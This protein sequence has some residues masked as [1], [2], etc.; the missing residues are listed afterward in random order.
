MGFAP[1]AML[2]ALVLTFVNFLKYLVNKQWNGAVTQ[3]IS[4]VSGV[5][6][7]VLVASTDWAEGINV[8]DK[9]LATLNGSSLVFVGLCLASTAGVLTE[10]KKAFDAND[11]AKKPDLTGGSSTPA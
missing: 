7:V 10:F 1:V 8:G 6:G 5:V 2:A 9:S 11:S 4:W 3:L